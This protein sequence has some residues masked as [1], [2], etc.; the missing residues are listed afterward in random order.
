[1]F[2]FLFSYHLVQRKYV[3]RETFIQDLVGC[4]FRRLIGAHFHVPEG[5]TDESEL[6]FVVGQLGALLSFSRYRWSD[7]STRMKS[8]DRE[9]VMLREGPRGQHLSSALALLIGDGRSVSRWHRLKI[10]E[11][12]TFITGSDIVLETLHKEKGR[13]THILSKSNPVVLVQPGTWM[14]AKVLSDFA[15]FSCVC[16][17]PFAV[18]LFEAGTQEVLWPAFGKEF[19]ELVKEFACE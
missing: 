10:E 18:D 11:V 16:G 3:G 17:P 4:D 9:A 8:V 14:A 5:W 13:V 19:P 6:R 15:V 2:C 12:W 1:M 7:Y